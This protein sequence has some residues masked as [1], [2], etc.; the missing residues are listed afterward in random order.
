M[1]IVYLGSGELGIPSL[2][3]LA[4]AN[5]SLSLVVTQK[6][7]RAGRGQKLAQTP[8]AR[9]AEE[10]SAECIETE[11]VNSEQMIAE[12]AARKPDI[13]VV[14]AFGQKIG[15]E[16][17]RL[18]PRGAI[19]VHPSLLP[20]YRGAAPVNWAII[21]GE[22]RTGVSIIALT[23]QM[24]AGDIIAQMATD[25]RPDETAGEL[26]ER[27]GQLAPQLLQKTLRQIAFGT[28]VYQKQDD[29]KATRAPKLKKS[30][31]NIGFNESAQVLARKIRGLWPWPGASAY[32]MGKHTGK[33]ERVTFAAA[34]P[35]E[36]GSDEQEKGVVDAKLNIVCAPG[37]LKVQRIKPAGKKV[38]DFKD[39]VNGRQLTP[40]DIFMPIEGN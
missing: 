37:T 30:D 5:H 34:H 6:A 2:A 13:L 14:I 1:K 10:N 9:W 35:A 16:L 11:D 31:G 18:V 36:A 25:I 40:G 33:C 38:M 12:I 15:N 3:A 17:L 8:V 29:S 23:E 26:Q 32:Y 4:Q 28:A 7:H 21:N 19:N 39:F 20:K 24:D 27:L 22:E